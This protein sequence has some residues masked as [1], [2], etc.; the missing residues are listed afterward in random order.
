MT[1][2]HRAPDP[3]WTSSSYSQSNGG[4]CIEWAPGHARATGEFLVRD[5]KNPGG[6]R[7]RLTRSGFAGLVELAKRA[8]V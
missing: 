6:P 3:D 7:L 4:E 5:S 2:N 1:L 8:D